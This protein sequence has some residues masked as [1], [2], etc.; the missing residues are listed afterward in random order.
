MTFHEITEPDNIVSGGDLWSRLLASEGPWGE[1][2]RGDPAAYRTEKRYVRR[3]GQSVWAGLSMSLVRD[4]IGRPLHFVAVIQDISERQRAKEELEQARNR[5]QAIYDNIDDFISVNDLR[6]EFIFAS[7]AS[8]NLLGYGPSDLVGTNV[9]R[10]VHPEDY[11]VMYEAYRKFNEGSNEHLRVRYRAFRRDGAYM[12]VETYARPFVGVGE[13]ER[14]I[15]CV[16]RQVPEVQLTQETLVLGKQQTGEV[17]HTTQDLLQKDEAGTMGVPGLLER[18]EIEDLVGPKLV[19]PRSANYPFGVLL[20]DIDFFKDI[21]DS[22]GRAVGDEV[23]RRV[24]RKLQ[25]VCRTEDA[26][27]RFGGDEFLVVLPNT[28]APGTI[29]AGEKLISSVREIDWSGTPIEGGVTISVGAACISY[30]AQA[31]LPELIGILEMQL[32]Q[33]KEAGRDRLVMNTRQTSQRLGG[34]T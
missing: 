18:R 33:A 17:G 12:W 22:Y 1:G 2:R 24:G 26:I 16:S 20:V 34:K 23:F 15:V 9:F 11:D 7:A 28:N 30:G 8:L 25:E 14:E 31:T 29:I 3:D 4:E 32:I 10:Y 21:N 5:Y 27:G 13:H 19:S 6:G